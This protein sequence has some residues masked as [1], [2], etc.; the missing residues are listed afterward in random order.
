MNNYRF[1][2]SIIIFLSFIFSIIAQ[3]THDHSAKIGF[4][5]LSCGMEGEYLDQIVKDNI[6]RKAQNINNIQTN[7]SNLPYC[8]DPASTKYI[9]LHIHYI[10]KSD[11]TYKST[12]SG[13]S[14]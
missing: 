1:F 2:T 7:T 11:G 8:N 6:I 12:T 10:L 3:N 5:T 9:T 13:K 4:K 14:G